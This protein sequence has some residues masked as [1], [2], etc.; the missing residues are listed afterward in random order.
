MKIIQTT[1]EEFLKFD[2]IIGNGRGLGCAE[3]IGGVKTLFLA[4]YDPA[5]VHQ[6]SES[7]PKIIDDTPILTVYRFD[8]EDGNG[9]M[10]DTGSR[11]ISQGSRLYESTG[12]FSWNNITVEDQ[13][14]IDQL[15]AGKFWAWTE[16]FNGKVLLF[17]KENGCWF[18]TVVTQTGVAKT[19]RSGYTLSIMARERFSFPLNQPFTNFPFD[20]LAN[21][22]VDPLYPVIP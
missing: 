15:T 1:P 2:C 10:V 8:L 9:G 5:L 19:D 12:D 21:I 3:S 22:T 7:A 17:G 4:N 11:D 6:F 14:Q 16:D 20:N 13:V 18:P